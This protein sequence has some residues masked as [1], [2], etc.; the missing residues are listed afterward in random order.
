MDVMSGDEIFWDFCVLILKVLSLG[1]VLS[2]G[3][4]VG[5]QFLVLQIIAG[6]QML[7][8]GWI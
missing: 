5:K 8:M 2:A 3:I 1:Q 4:C 6:L 7:S